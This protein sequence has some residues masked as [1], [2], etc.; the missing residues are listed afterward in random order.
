MKSVV[1]SVREGVVAKLFQRRMK[2][3]PRE[4]ETFLERE[5][6][7]KVLAAAQGLGS[8]RLVVEVL[9][10][11][12]CFCGH[13]QGQRF[14]LDMSGNLLT[15]ECPATVCIHLLSPLPAIVQSAQELA[16][17][18]KDPASLVFTRYGCFD[19]GLKCGGWGRVICAVSVVDHKNTHDP[20]E[21][22]YDGDKVGNR[23]NGS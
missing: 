11:G 21:Y 17:A 9:E 1:Q 23:R 19:V 15:K 8:K 18:G 13:K 6:N 20:T 3:S 2:Y 22:G 5:E 16:F 14:V 4:M 10:A 7:Q 12:G